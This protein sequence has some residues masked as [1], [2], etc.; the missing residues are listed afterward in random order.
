M[1][2]N[3]Y[4]LQTHSIGDNNVLFMLLVP[5][6]KYMFEQKWLF[7]KLNGKLTEATGKYGNALI[8]E[9]IWTANRM[10]TKT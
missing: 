8:S 1:D 5:R 2:L 9:A 7:P 10:A 6:C 4:A 3:H